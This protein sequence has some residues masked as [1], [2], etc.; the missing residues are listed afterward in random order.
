VALMWGAALGGAP[1]TVNYVTVHWGHLV[2]FGGENV[3]FASWRNPLWLL[4]AGSFALS[5][6]SVYQW[7]LNAYDEDRLKAGGL[8][9][10]LEGA[11]LLSPHP[12]LGY[13]ALAFLLVIN[14]A[15]SGAALAL[16]DREDRARELT[17]GARKPPEAGRVPP[18]TLTAVGPWATHLPSSS[19]TAVVGP[20]A[21][22][23]LAGSRTEAE[24]E[25]RPA[26]HEPSPAPSPLRALSVAQGTALLPRPKAAVVASDAAATRSDSRDYQQAIDVLQGRET[27]TTEE[28]QQA[29]RC[30]QPAAA[31]LMR[32]LEEA[33]AV[34]RTRGRRRVLLSARNER[35]AA[36]GRASMLPA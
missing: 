30:R 4:V 17:E 2:W 21:T 26:R 10:M 15:S 1:P 6:K 14:A 20:A 25:T 34:E 24:R 31:A 8:V 27:V 33:G 16:R 23:R 32:Q 35:G 18:R 12:L 5:V 11:L 13:A 19:A 22:A 36:P 7:G 28:L 29:L 3:F 9:A